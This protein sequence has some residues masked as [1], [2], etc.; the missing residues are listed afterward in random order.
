MLGGA[1]KDVG[2]GTVSGGPA[3]AIAGAIKAGLDLG[4]KAMDGKN[5]KLYG[6][7]D[8]M[9]KQ[10]EAKSQ[11]IQ[12][13]LAAKKAEQEAQ[14]KKAAEKAKTKRIIYITVGVVAA[15]LLTVATIMIVK[16]NRRS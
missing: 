13:A 6:G 3:G 2:G 14:A 16:A 8:L 7:L 5:R 10:Q 4:G 9:Q 15:A 12:A 11:I 1:A